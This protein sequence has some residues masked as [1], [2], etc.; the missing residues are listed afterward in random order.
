MIASF[1]KV[2]DL[3]RQPSR[4]KGD[5]EYCFSEK[6][7]FFQNVA[8]SRKVDAEQKHLLRKGSSSLDIF[9]TRL[10]SSCSEK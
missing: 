3:K 9:I 1:E 4:K 6:L 7:A 8:F 2:A 10:E 5:V